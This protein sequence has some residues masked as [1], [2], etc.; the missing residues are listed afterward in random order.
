MSDLDV[1]NEQLLSISTPEVLY[2]M[3]MI[4]KIQ[5]RMKDPEFINVEHIRVYDQLG[6]EFDNFFNMYT[7]IFVKVVKGENLD[8]IASALYYKDQVAKGLIT[9]EHL[10]DKVATKYLPEKLKAESDIKLKSMKDD[11][12]L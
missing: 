12:Q 7:G 8:I 2:I 9:E 4:K 5:T 1:S 6:R 10:A 3:K 11:G